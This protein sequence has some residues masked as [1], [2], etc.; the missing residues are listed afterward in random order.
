[1]TQRLIIIT[2]LDCPGCNRFKA[3]NISGMSHLL[4][5]L[6][7]YKL[8]YELIE[9]ESKANYEAAIKKI[10]LYDPRLV[11]YL[12]FYPSFI[13]VDES[14]I[15][16]NI[17]KAIPYG[18]QVEGYNNGRPIIPNPSPGKVK[19]DSEIILKWLLKNLKVKPRKLIV[20]KNDKPLK[21]QLQNSIPSENETTHFG[22]FS[23]MSSDDE[24]III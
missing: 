13:L 12:K 23:D 7:N 15:K 22:I 6:D 21:V 19:L 24:L 18:C 11:S 2:A 8:K 1:M 5:Q 16:D 20:T 9:V 10:S 14:S 4:K 17:L 3:N